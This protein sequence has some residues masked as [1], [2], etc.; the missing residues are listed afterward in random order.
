MYVNKN[1]H[2]V[3]NVAIGSENEN[4]QD[5]LNARSLCS[6]QNQIDLIGE[7]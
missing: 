5:Y 4:G 6:E 3:C 1:S 2:I 7:K